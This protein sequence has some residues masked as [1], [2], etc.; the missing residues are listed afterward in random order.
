M[1]VKFD[2]NN[3][4]NILDIPDEILFLIFKK[5]N[6][7]DVFS[8]LVGV[9]QRFDRLAFDSLY[10][11]HLN[12]ATITNFNSFYDQTT[13]MDRE[14]LSRICKNILSQIYSKVHQLTVEEYS[15]KE[16]LHAGSYPQLNS[17]SLINF[18]EETL[19]QYLTG[20]GFDFI[21]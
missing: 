2:M 8:S 16:I 21:P 6:T 5:V 18:Q 17:L 7:V 14:V 15:I 13:L 9:N 12:M 3:H 20:I 10:I 4:L 1:M 19:Y 11:R